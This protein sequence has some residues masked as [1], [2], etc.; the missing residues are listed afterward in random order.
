VFAAM[1][2]PDRTAVLLDGHP[3]W[4]EA[5]ETVLNRI[6]VAVVGKATSIERALTLLEHQDPDLFVAEIKN[7][8]DHVDLAFLQSARERARSAKIIV[9]SMLEEKEHIEAALHAGAVA[10][11]LKSAHPDDLTTTVRQIFHS[12]VFL[13]SG[14]TTSGPVSVP[15]IV[16]PSHLTPRE[17]EI[18]RLAADGHSNAQMA[19]MLWV[20]EQTVKF[21]LSNIYRKLDVANRTEASRWAQLHGLLN[22]AA[23]ARAPQ[24]S[25]ARAQ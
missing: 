18:L 5:V 13:A 20:T 1:N 22:A 11:V 14:Q 4:L 25:M 9:L 24:A 19:K 15:H 23:V 6:D 16:Q 7:G 3:L 12:S 21:H 8:S 17:V 2:A 10:Y